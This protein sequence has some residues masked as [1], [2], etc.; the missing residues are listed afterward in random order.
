M[1]N[2]LTL[3]ELRD[4]RI[5]AIDA[6]TNYGIFADSGGGWNRQESLA[7]RNTEISAAGGSSSYGIHF[8]GNT[9]ASVDVAVSKIWGHVASTDN[10]GI[11]NYG[12]GVSVVQGSRLV[13]STAT[14]EVQGSAII[15][16]TELNGGAASAAGWIGCLG[17]WDE[18]A[19]FYANTC[20]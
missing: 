10:Y 11:Y 20:P 7:I 18:S 8:A 12:T 19:V 13:G 5:D 2:R 6:T 9:S 1:L 4:S 17:V 15:S 3:A 14:L 16:T